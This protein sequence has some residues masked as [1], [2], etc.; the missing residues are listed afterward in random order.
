[1]NEASRTPW[2]VLRT[3]A[4]RA[5]PRLLGI[6]ARWRLLAYGFTFPVFYAAFFLYLLWSGVWLLD[7]DGI[8]V[9]FDFTNHYAAGLMSLHADTAAIY[10][11]TEFI[12]AQDSLVVGASHV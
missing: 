6:F 11:P 8:P 12:K 10:S 7:R 2:L 9:Y 3:G 1:M 5:C 4:D